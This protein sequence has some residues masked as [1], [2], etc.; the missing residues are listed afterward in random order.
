MAM[1]IILLTTLL[2]TVVKFFILS[3][4]TGITSGLNKG[5]KLQPDEKDIRQE[6][7]WNRWRWAYA[8]LSI[9]TLIYAIFVL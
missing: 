2:V 6:K 8:A 4:T 1:F 9:I 7:S 3:I 5:L